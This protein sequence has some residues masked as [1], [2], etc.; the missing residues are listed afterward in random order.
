[1]P[2]SGF[3]HH[4]TSANSLPACAAATDALINAYVAWR[5]ACARVRIAYE[6]WDVCEPLDRDLTFAAYLAALECEDHAADIYAR[7]VEHV[8]A[9]LAG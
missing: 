2:T 6:R 9:W 4:L 7:R 8:T 1:M 5:E 3:T